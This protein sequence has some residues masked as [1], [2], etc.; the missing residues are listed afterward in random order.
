[1]SNIT[2]QDLINQ[3][4]DLLQ[5]VKETPGY[6]FVPFKEFEEWKRVADVFLN[7]NYP[8]NQQSIDVHKLVQELNHRDTHCKRLLAILKAIDAIPPSSKKEFD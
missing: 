4:E 5:K 8:N 1:M 2:L 7:N 6:G 3:G